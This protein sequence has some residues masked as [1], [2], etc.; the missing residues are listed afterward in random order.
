MGKTMKLFLVLALLVSLVGFAMSVISAQQAGLSV[1]DLARMVEMNLKKLNIDIVVPEYSSVEQTMTVT[2]KGEV[3]NIVLKSSFADIAVESGE[4]FQVRLQGNVTNELDDLLSWR[5]SDD[6]LYLDVAAVIK[7]NP[8]ATGLYALVTLPAKQFRE[9]ELA[10]VSGSVQITGIE[11]DRIQ[12]ESKSGNLNIYDSTLTEAVIKTTS[13][14]ILILNDDPME[15]QCRTDSGSIDIMGEDLSG[16]LKTKS[17]S[18]SLNFGDLT[19]DL[20]LTTDSGHM[21][22]Y[23]RGSDLAY[24]F[25]SESGDVRVHQDDA[26]LE[27]SGTAG[28]GQHSIRG[29]SQ[30]GSVTFEF[31]EEDLMIRE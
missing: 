8:T 29:S 18:I 24:R 19:N 11:A 21:E 31:I 3:H 4:E 14:D 12:M 9:F 13:G 20:V 1:A 16:S 26:E 6:T 25:T 27:A 15:F 7:E 2:P 23:Y 10:T 5:Q 17:G 22:I 28:E 30:S